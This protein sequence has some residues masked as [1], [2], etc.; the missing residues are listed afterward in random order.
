MLE[1]CLA[2][3]GRALAGSL[4]AIRGSRGVVVELA[5]QSHDLLA[6]IGEVLLERLASTKGRRTGIGPHAHAVV[7]DPLQLEQAVVH[8][9]REQLREQAIDRVAMLHA[10]LRKHRAVDRHAAAQPQIGVVAR[11]Q[12]FEMT[13]AADALGGREDPHREQNRRI[14]RGLPGRA[15]ARIDRLMESREIESLD[16]RPDDARAMVLRQ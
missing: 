11:A 3:L 10:K 7:R 6:R 4:L 8:Q 12:S 9:H 15:F 13:R 5:T 14:G 2:I 16:R 1:P